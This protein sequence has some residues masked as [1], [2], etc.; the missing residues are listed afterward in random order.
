MALRSANGSFLDE[1][2][3]NAALILA[4]KC[5]AGERDEKLEV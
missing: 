4:C 1:C 3:V 5:A 2:H